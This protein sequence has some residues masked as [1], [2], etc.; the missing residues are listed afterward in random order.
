[1]RRHP[2]APAA[3]QPDPGRRAGRRQDR[4]GRG[5][6]PA[7]RRR[8]GAAVVARGN[9]AGARPRPVAG[10]RQH[11]GRV[12][13]AP[14]GRDRR[15]AQQRAADH[16]V[17]RRGAHADRRR[18]RGRRQRRRQP[19]Q[20]GPGARRVAHPGGHHLAGIQEILRE[21]PGADPALPTGPGRG[22]GR[23]HRRGD[24]ARRRRQA[25]TASRR[26]DH[27]RGHRRCG[28]AVAPLHLRPPVAGQ[29]DQRARHRLRA[30]R[31]R[32]ARRAAAAGKPAPPRAGAGRGIAAAAPGTGHRPRPQ[33]AYHRPGKRVGR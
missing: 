9:P 25:G 22:A 29:G 7:H 8:R 16:P 24:A 26:A 15:R 23:G 1:M 31:P 2:P 3:E 18:R 30:G 28:E 5:P 21:G 4:G 20:A 27:G 17:H 32:P 11:E 19:A 10:R 12:R 13:A 33:R 14:Q 6:G